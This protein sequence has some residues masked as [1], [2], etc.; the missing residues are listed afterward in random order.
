VRVRD[1][2]V[3]EV[4]TPAAGFGDLADDGVAFAAEGT[5]RGGKAEVVAHFGAGRSVGGRM[6]GAEVVVVLHGLEGAAE[7]GVLEV[8]GWLEGSDGAGE[9]LADEEVAGAPGDLLAGTD[10]AGAGAGG[11][12]FAEVG[13]AQQMDVDGAGKV[14]DALEGSGDDESF[15]QFDHVF[16]RGRG[17]GGEIE[18][19]KGER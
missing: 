15:M 10:E 8:E 11:G 18:R 4:L 16:S 17:R 7:H 13:V 19:P 5:E 2:R 14:E 1:L 6:E 12:L 9:V 3:G